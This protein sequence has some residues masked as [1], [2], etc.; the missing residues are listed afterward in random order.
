M[1][2]AD[3][4]P[5]CANRLT[6]VS[7][8]VFA[9]GTAAYI[10]DRPDVLFLEADLVVKNSDAVCLHHKGKSWLDIVRWVAVVISILEN[11]KKR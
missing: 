11:T 4:L 1:L 8:F 5:R 2:V 6:N 9:L 7:I 3:F 10:T